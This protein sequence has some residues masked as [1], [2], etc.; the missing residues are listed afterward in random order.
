MATK[1]EITVFEKSGGPLSK[2]IS[3]NDDGTINADG[4]ACKMAVGRA[5]RAELAGIEEF[6]ALIERLDFNEAITLGALRDDLASEVKVVTEDQLN[7]RLNVIARTADHVV[8]RASKPAF[9]LIDFDRKGMP[10]EVAVKIE[11]CG[12]LW[13]TLL[14]VMPALHDAARVVRPSTS[15]GLYNAVT[16]ERYAGSG[17]AHIYIAVANGRDNERFLQT[18]HDRCWLMGLGWILVGSAGQMLERSLI[19]KAVGGSE[20]LVF[21]GG[22]VLIKPLKQ[23]KEARRPVA[24]AGKVV[25]ASTACPKLTDTEQARVNKLKTQAR[26]RVAPESDKVRAA[27]IEERLPEM[28]NRTGKSEA[29]CRRALEEF[30]CYKLEG[31]IVLEFANKVL[32]GATVGNVLDDPERFEGE[33]LADPIEGIAYGA[34]TAQVLRRRDNGTP[35]IKS[36]AHGGISYTL[37]PK[38]KPGVKA[39]AQW[40]VN[41]YCEPKLSSMHNAREAII[42][43]GV[44]CSYD[45]FHN[46]LLFGYTGDHVRHEVQA[47]VGEVSDNGIIRL[48]QAISVCFGIDIEEKATRD[49]VVSIAMEHCFDPVRDMLDQAQ[50]EWDGTERLDEMAVTY[51]NC[52]NT[53]LNRAI[54]RKTMIAAVRRVRQPGCKFDNIAVMESE[55]GWAKSTAW[56]ILAGDE[57]FSDAS[58]LGHGAREVQE[59]LAEVWIHENADLAGMRKAEVETVKTFASR[60]SDD[61]RP[62]YGHF[63]KK[64]KRHSIEVGTTNSDE[65]LQSQTGN[66][67]FWPLKILRPIDIEQLRRDRLLLWGEAAFYEAQGESITLP[68]RLW[69]SAAEQQEERRVKD[70]WEDILDNIPSHVMGDENSSRYTFHF[71]KEGDTLF[72]LDA[73]V[74]IRYLDRKDRT[75]VVASADLLK[76]VLGIPAHQQNVAHGMRLSLVMKRLGWKRGSGKV[77]INGVQVRGYSRRISAQAAKDYQWKKPEPYVSRF[78]VEPLFKP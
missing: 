20:R 71:M 49:A 59:Q 26:E 70:P 45:T 61:A 17:G 50:G 54:V 15:T 69:P 2:R 78:N 6:A 41:R 57:N 44:E 73:F 22:P 34:Q 27:Y 11:N 25:R 31:D 33:S 63:L 67:R 29:E 40:R 16:G 66:R 35:W 72:D 43:L 47:M 74:Q 8:Y 36:F 9:A 24:H 19:D 48:R 51:F 5:R 39:Q 65:Y 7:G 23:D 3:L 30:C 58:I 68:E 56:R 75:E 1:I 4:S 12:G 64:Q 52:A 62:A 37:I 60:Q 77:Y 55:E 21:E 32:K 42:A 10:K 14:T 46:A 38:L 53:S 28:M 76:Y 18:L 13:E